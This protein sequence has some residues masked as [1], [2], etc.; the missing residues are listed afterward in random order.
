MSYT[1]SDESRVPWK[2]QILESTIRG[3]FVGA[4]WGLTFLPYNE[5]MLARESGKKVNMVYN[6]GNLGRA[7]SRNS[8][9]FGSI[10]SL[11][12]AVT[13][14]SENYVSNNKLINAFTAGSMTGIYVGLCESQSLSTRALLKSL[15]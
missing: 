8:V 10:V 3:S 6:A 4:V 2:V 12:T 13:C 15:R 7:M 1:V 9:F 14:F 11:Y 5:H